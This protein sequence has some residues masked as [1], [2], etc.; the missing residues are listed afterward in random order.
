MNDKTREIIL[1]ITKAA[2][3]TA[4]ALGVLK[5]SGVKNI[6][7]LVLLTTL[8]GTLGNLL[9]SWMVARLLDL[10]K[11]LTRTRPGEVVAAFGSYPLEDAGFAPAGGKGRALARLFQAGYPV[12]DGC[13]VLPDAF[14]GDDLRPAAWQQLARQL[15]RLRAGKAIPF[16]VRSSALQE[17]SARGS[18]AGEFESVLGV[19]SDAEIREA[20]RTV[21]QSRRSDRVSSYTREQS[22]DG[23]EHAIAVVI[24]KL[25]RPD[26]AGVLF[27]ADPLTG[28]LNQM[29][30]NFV[31][32]LGE[33]LVSGQV[34][35]STFTFDRPV[36]AYHGPAELEPVA[37]TLHR[38][39]HN[40]ENDLGCP[41]DIEWAA[42]GGKVY[43]LQA[44]PITTLNGFDPVLAVWNDTL[45]GNFLWSA[46]NLMEA[47]PEVLTPFTASLRSY[48][49]THGGPAL[50]VKNHS[51]NGIIGGRFYANLSVQV[52]A[53]AFLFGGDARRAYQQ[54][55]GW[56]GEVPP[57]MDI[58]VLPL[59][60]EDWFK[61]VL[62]GLLQSTLM[63]GQY[64][65]QAPRFLAANRQKCAELRQKVKQAAGK[66]QLA[67]LWQNAIGPLYRDSMIHV[68][69]ASS[70]AQFKLEREL[71]ELV[72]E[73]EANAL[74]SNLS[75]ADARLESLGPAAG[76][77]KVLRGEM[78]REEYLDHYGH[79]G[80]NEPECAWPRP[81]E[82]PAWLER[83]LAEW[84]K[85]PV[86]VDG[87]LARQQAAYEAAWQRFCQRYPR[88]VKSTQKRIQQAAEAA[89]QRE[90]VRSEATRGITV[91]RAFALRAGELLGLG[92]DVFFLTID[93]VLQA[94]QSETAIPAVQRIAARKET[95]QRY[96]SLPPY[97]AMICGRFDPFAWAADPNRRSDVFDAHSQAAVSTPAAEQDD[98]TLHG[99]AGALGVVEGVVRRLNSM[100]DSET[101]QPGEVLVTTMTNIGWTPLFPRA[102]A[103]VTDLGAPLSHAA[104][105]ARE[106]GIPAV[107]G[108]GNATMRLKTGDRVRVDGGKGLVQIL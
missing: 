7:A 107:V 101:F 24:Q 38:L 2:G 33:K 75:G 28:N 63:F 22:L 82:D 18:F 98:H 57:Q 68:V 11:R 64:R 56:W 30:G 91:L 72:G 58:P 53:F 44:R 15:A 35:A 32:G 95:F 66:P 84:Q 3:A 37:K 79:R 25:V 34:S 87:L 102:A 16:A 54:I 74:L 50:S 20:L 31:S 71:R 10:H 104:I 90:A 105:V 48:L 88:R 100:D 78:S 4:C 8:A 21:L 62:P 49:D 61:R 106:L 60:G 6:A 81:M 39:A 99:F 19:Q 83:K 52:S 41:Q 86:D 77:G 9:F 108:C 73:D 29:T 26:Y 27:T 46:T 17:D 85:S 94:L 40:I 5:F 51:L 12:P 92:E 69:A 47:S 96:Q 36:G 23:G 13:I 59:S 97:P 76:L 55:A 45:T 65:K 43:I 89:R 70:D 80:V 14:D 42:A 1:S 67:D 103:I 93:E